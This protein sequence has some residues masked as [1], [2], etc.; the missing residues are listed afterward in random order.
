M[1]YSDH[2]ALSNLLAELDGGKYGTVT[3]EYETLH[4]LRTNV[5]NFLSASRRAPANT[6]LN[7]VLGAPQT[8]LHS[9]SHP[10]PRHNRSSANGQRNDSTP[11]NVINLDD[12]PV[13][14]DSI[15]RTGLN[16]STECHAAG[17][18]GSVVQKESSNTA[19]GKA[20]T[21]VLIIDS[22]EEDGDH[23]VRNKP[24]IIT[25]TNEYK[26]RECLDSQLLLYLKQAKLLEQEGH[27][28]QLVAYEQKQTKIDHDAAIQST[29][30][31]TIQY[32][33]VI[34]RTAPDQQP[35]E[36]LMVSFYCMSV[37]VVQIFVR[38]YG[39]L[40]VYMKLTASTEVSFKEFVWKTTMW[41]AC[42]NSCKFLFFIISI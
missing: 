36:E 39:E 7:P 13:D 4:A 29:W 6:C 20:S 35:H 24:S 11:L 32:E 41:T 17:D 1:D 18:I 34:L 21:P 16:I 14:S 19:D 5:I 8:S 30:Q 37:T 38:V 40:Y 28:K 2:F 12:D 26:S 33:K 42:Y 15:M 10:R 22:D 25:G 31:P 3:K 27:S 23:Q 9:S